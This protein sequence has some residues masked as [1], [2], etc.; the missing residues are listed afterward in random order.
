MDQSSFCW[1]TT[2]YSHIL[3]ISPPLILQLKICLQTGVGLDRYKIYYSYIMTPS[4][5]WYYKCVWLQDN[6]DRDVP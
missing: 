2:N 6:Q 1:R 4:K 5:L 3:I